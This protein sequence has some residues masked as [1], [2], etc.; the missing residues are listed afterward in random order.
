MTVFWDIVPH[1]LIET[2]WCFWDAYCLHHRAENEG[3]KHLWNVSLFLWDYAVQHPVD[4]HLQSKHKLTQS[5]HAINS[6]NHMVDKKKLNLTHTNH[7]INSHN[8]MADQKIILISLFD[9]LRLYC[10][11]GIW[12]EEYK[13]QDPKE[14][15]FYNWSNNNAFK[16][17]SKSE[18]TR[19][20]TLLW[21]Q[22]KLTF[23][24]YGQNNIIAP[25]SKL[26]VKY[27]TVMQN[28]QRAVIL[29]FVFNISK[30]CE[31]Q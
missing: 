26:C 6:Y 17:H 27:T 30:F 28:I 7:A 4:S 22:Y 2:E 20:I 9:T 10:D 18:N 16:V 29:N 25:R 24:R 13:L 21:L 5:N 23:H 1:S 11:T 12:W 31:R 19:A 3:S 14:Q 15:Y 8:H